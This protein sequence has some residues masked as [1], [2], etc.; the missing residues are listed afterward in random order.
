VCLLGEESFRSVCVDTPTNPVKGQ[1][2]ASTQVL[3][4]PI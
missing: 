1:E 3:Y 2:R 4:N